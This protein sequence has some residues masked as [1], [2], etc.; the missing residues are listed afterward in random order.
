[1]PS[2]SARNKNPGNLAYG[3]FSQAQGATGQD[4]HLAIFKTSAQGFRA[5]MTLLSGSIY[6]ALSLKDAIARYAPSND[7]NQPEV[8]ANFVSEQTDVALETHL[9]QLSCPQL[10]GV[11][12]AMVM[13]E[14]WQP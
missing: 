13:F 12:W 8:Y 3:Q 4:G 11:A 1:M 2:R 10:A 9:N 5:M 6:G 14:G 7:N